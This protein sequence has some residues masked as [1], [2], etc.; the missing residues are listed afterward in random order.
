M[1]VSREDS[2]I[3]SNLIYGAEELQA[4]QNEMSI[5]EHP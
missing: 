3:T 1:K 4:L 5:E 2:E